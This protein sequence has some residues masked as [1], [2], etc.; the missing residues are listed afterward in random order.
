MLVMI[1]AFFITK[2]ETNFACTG[3][4]GGYCSYSNTCSS[5]GGHVEKLPVRCRCG[6]ACCKCTDTCPGGSTCM[7]E[8]ETCDGMQDTND[9]CGNRFCCT[10]TAQSTT[11]SSTTQTTTQQ[12]VI[13]CP[14]VCVAE[15]LPTDTVEGEC[16][17]FIC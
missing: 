11:P 13:N 5:L 8:D 4:L 7:S 6:K 10:P 9:C 17:G 2:G 16:C 14:K 12:C 1:V 15:C 3:V